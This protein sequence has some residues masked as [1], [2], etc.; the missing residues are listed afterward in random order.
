MRQQFWT[1]SRDAFWH[2]KEGQPDCPVGLP[3]DMAE[4]KRIAWAENWIG[5]KSLESSPEDGDR[6]SGPHLKAI[7]PEHAVGY[8]PWHRE[9]PPSK[10]MDKLIALREQQDLVAIDEDGEMPNETKRGDTS[11]ECLTF[12]EHDGQITQGDI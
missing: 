6:E 5:P 4:V 1:D 3:F 2:G 10:V 9:T 12:C 7:L 11:D 8:L